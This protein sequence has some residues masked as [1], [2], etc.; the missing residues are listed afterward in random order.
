[1]AAIGLLAI[2]AVIAAAVYL[3]GGYYSVAANAPEA[4][5]IAWTLVRVR[6]ALI[7]QRA[8]TSVPVSVDNPA[9]LEAGARSFATRGCPTCHGAPGVEWAKFSEGLSPEAADLGEVARQAPIGQIFW[10]VKNGIKMTGMPSFGRIGVGDD[11]IWRIA[12][13]VRKFPN[14]SAADFKA[15]TSGGVG[16]PNNQP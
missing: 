9:L 2:L 6:N 4:G 8:P 1:L 11:E 15:W 14:V 12:A 5:P 16:P 7:A 3:F 13:F 10:V